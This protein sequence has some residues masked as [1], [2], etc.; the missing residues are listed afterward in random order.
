MK[1][2]K[3]IGQ[4]LSQDLKLRVVQ[5][6]KRFIK[7]FSA[8]YK[9]LLPNIIVY[10]SNENS[11]DFLKV[12]IAL[13]NNFNAVIGETKSGVLMM[14]G[15]VTSNLSS[16]NPAD[17]ISPTPLRKE[18]I[19]FIIPSDE[20]PDDMSEISFLD[21]CSTGN[22]VVLRNKNL[23]YISDYEIINHYI[24]EL[25]ELVL[26]RYSIAMQS[27]INTFFIG[28]A[29]DTTT[30]QL[31][32]DLY[33]GAPFAKVTNLFDPRDNIYTLQNN[34]I[35]SVFVELKSEYQNKIS[36][37]NNILGINS[38]AVEK[39]SGVSD[40]EAKSNMS[41]TTSNSN[42]YLLSR[43]EPLHK[44]NKRFNKE[45]EAVYNDNVES[46]LSSINIEKGDIID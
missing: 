2:M 35:A 16:E 18:D 25:A 45:F 23:N 37:L 46:E 7:F 1:E 22:F 8:R 32:N 15:Y 36:E 6:K 28:E 10:K 3:G 24:D 20:I 4:E 42:I 39:S 9:E 11:V 43:N 30:N 41:F 44:L 5:H 14:M 33:N 38:L 21:N 29:N 34:N 12:E 31:V 17:L 40:V 27:K 19:H 26:S 13:R